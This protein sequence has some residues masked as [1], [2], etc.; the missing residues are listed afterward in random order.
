MQRGEAARAGTT[1]AARS[2]MRTTFLALAVVLTAC[3]SQ[4][5]PTGVGASELPQCSWPASLDPPSDGGA[6]GW[7][8]ARTYL[9]C[10]DG[11]DTALCLSDDPTTCPG[12]NPIAGATYTDCVNQCHPDEYAVASG[13]PPQPL[14]DG[15]DAYPA[16]PNLPASCR[17]VGITPSG[18]GFSCCP[19]E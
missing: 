10:K 3:S 8:V 16:E 15:G 19:C 18:R 17:S 7:S 12:S 13:G 1:S 5:D 6:W 14:P 11:D 9:S 2:R 4:S